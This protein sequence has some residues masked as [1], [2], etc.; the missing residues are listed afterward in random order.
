MRLFVAH[1]LKDTY[2]LEDISTQ[3]EFEHFV[4]DESDFIKINGKILWVIGIINTHNRLIRLELSYDRNTYI[5][6][7]IIKSDI[8]T[9][10]IVVIEGCSA[11]SWL[12]HPFSGYI[13]FM[14]N[15]GAGNFRSGLD[16]TSQIEALWNYLKHLI[17]S[18]Y[19]IIPSEKFCIIFKR[20][21]FRRLINEL[22]NINKWNKLIDVLNYIRNVGIENLYSIDQLNKIID[23]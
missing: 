2:I 17:K 8:K 6:K 11:Y 20:R 9:G 23:K 12:S 19:Y 3:N 21:E 22:N 7:K 16:S 15:H 10:N 14:H 4:I 18:I 13:H 5:M 1:L